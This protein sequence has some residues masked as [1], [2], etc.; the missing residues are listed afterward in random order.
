MRPLVV[1]LLASAALAACS[2]SD[3]AS[4]P[5]VSPSVDAASAPRNDAVNTDANMAATQQTPGA[6]SFT[7]DQARGRIEHA[8][9]TNVT[10][11]TQGTDGVWHGTAM[12]G[13]SSV[14]V[15]VDYRGA[16]TPPGPESGPN[17]GDSASS[18]TSSSSTAAQ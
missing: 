1:L 16:V 11:L 8:G 12:R 15:S 14:A 13:G 5:A 10:A 18:S 2:R 17:A 6:N 9:Y 7:E 4:G 3:N